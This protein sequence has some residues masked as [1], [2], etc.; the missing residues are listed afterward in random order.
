M[1]FQ[2]HTLNQSQFLK[3]TLRQ[4][5][6]LLL[7]TLMIQLLTMELT[8]QQNSMPHGVAIVKVQL[9][10]MNKL[11]KRQLCFYNINKICVLHVIISKIEQKNVLYSILSDSIKRNIYTLSHLKV[12]L[13]DKLSY[14]EYCV[15]V[16][17]TFYYSHNY[18]VSMLLR[19]TS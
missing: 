11:L 14:A 7:K 10:S 3:I 5:K 18:L 6:Q 2:N 16:H 8:H 17:V 4:S 13:G 9:Q 15:L 12:T 19:V 1:V